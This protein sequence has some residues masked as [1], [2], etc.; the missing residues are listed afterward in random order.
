MIRAIIVLMLLPVMLMGEVGPFQSV[1]FAWD[2]ALSHG[3]NVTYRLKY[4]LS[5]NDYQWAID[6]G[7]N[8]T[9]TVTNP[10]SGYL[11]FTCVAVAPE[12]VIQ[13]IVIQPELESEPSN[14]LS[15]T[16]PPAAPLR[17]RASRYQFPTIKM[18]GTLN[19]GMEWRTLALVTNDPVTLKGAIGSMLFRASTNI[20]PFP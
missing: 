2:R 11:Y 8:T 6:V 5:T 14:I 13:G 3:S 1:K 4:G 10:T 12:V 17:F 16:N 9:C 7:T 18:E 19:G 20:P 15:V